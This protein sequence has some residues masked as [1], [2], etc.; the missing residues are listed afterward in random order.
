MSDVKSVEV[1]DRKELSK[2]LERFNKLNIKS[3]VK[4]SLTEG[5]RYCV[6]PKL[7]ENYR[8][9]QEIE[10]IWHGEWADPELEYKDKT[11]NYWDVEDALWQD[12]KE[13][14]G[15][16]DDEEAFD[17]YVQAHAVDMLDDWL[18][19]DAEA[20]QENVEEGCKGKGCR[21]KLKEAKSGANSPYRQVI[22][23]HFNYSM[24]FDFLDIVTDLVERI[25]FDEYKEKEDKFEYVW[26][27]IDNY[28]YWIKDQWTVLEAYVSSP[29]DLTESSWYDAL[30]E[31][32]SDVVAICNEIA[33]SEE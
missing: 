26:E 22:G 12:F 25:D 1:K 33:G 4:R 14:G 19:A 32:C 10:F 31:L 20:N 27:D 7:D 21:R 8:G 18:A 17:K 3:T 13:E 6:T 23:K 11:F 24:D 5:C 29:G 2:L 15:A 16:E 28:L 30:D 9:V